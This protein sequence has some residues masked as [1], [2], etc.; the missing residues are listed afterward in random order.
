M[1]SSQNVF[2]NLGVALSLTRCAATVAAAIAVAMSAKAL[3]LLLMARNCA[4]T[5][6]EEFTDGELQHHGNYHSAS[7][8]NAQAKHHT[9]SE[10]AGRTVWLGGLPAEVATGSLTT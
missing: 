5:Q 1:R 9:L 10:R 2:L 6:L 3:K 8:V 7:E 4:T